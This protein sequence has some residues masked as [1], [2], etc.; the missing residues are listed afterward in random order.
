MIRSVATINAAQAQNYY[1]DAL[2]PTGYYINSQE[3]QGTF[4]GR[5]KEKLGLPDIADRETFFALCMNQHPHTGETLT[6]RNKDHRIILWDVSFHAPKGVSLLSA[7]CGNSHL[8]DAFQEVVHNTMA[9]MEH[10]VM[11]RV[12]KGGRDED[13]QTGEFVYG[14]FL[15]QTARPAKGAVSDPH[16]HQHNTIF[17]LTWDNDSSEQRF[18]AAQ[19]REMNR[20]LPYYQARFH[21]RFADKLMS[22]GYNIKTSHKGWDIKGIP[23]HI[24]T[25]LS[26]RTNEIGRYAAEHGITGEKALDKLGAKTRGKKQKDMSMTELKAEWRK[27]IREASAGKEDQGE[28]IVRNKE[29]II[30]PVLLPETAVDYAVKDKFER[31]STISDRR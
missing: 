1:T 14:A 8:I 16:L 9:E 10:D 2:Q 4:H 5:L 7:L 11:T 27:Q 23:E 25:M 31:V 21:K 17:N 26:K 30:S 19:C 13:R 28:L 18:K 15:H 12:R 29:K 24:I 3:L 22:M 6:P 20:S